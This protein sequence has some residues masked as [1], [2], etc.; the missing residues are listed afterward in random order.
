MP[1]SDQDKYKYIIISN[2]QSTELRRGSFI[3][4]EAWAET[5]HNTYENWYNI[6]GAFNQSVW[7]Q[8]TT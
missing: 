1:F 8:W 6:D 2:F 5:V 4:A 3:H 7:T